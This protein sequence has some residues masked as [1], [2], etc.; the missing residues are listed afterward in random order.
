[1]INPVNAGIPLLKPSSRTEPIGAPANAPVA[2][3]ATHAQT[4]HRASTAETLQNG[5]NG[6]RSSLAS[7]APSPERSGSNAAEKSGFNFG[8]MLKKLTDLTKAI[9]EP[10]SQIFK[11]ITDLMK[12]GVNMAS[13]LGSLAMS[14]MSPVLGMVKS[15]VK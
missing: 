4:A 9:G 8:D 3:F 12:G 7:T 10:L 2:P 15:I 14:A 13:S 6:Q 1:M 5:L 11:V